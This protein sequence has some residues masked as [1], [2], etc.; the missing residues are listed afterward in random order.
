[1][2]TSYPA[3]F[4]ADDCVTVGFGPHV[5]CDRRPSEI[6]AAVVVSMLAGARMTGNGVADRP[7]RRPR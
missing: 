1:M 6:A 7:G 4:V 5:A 3:K 2:T